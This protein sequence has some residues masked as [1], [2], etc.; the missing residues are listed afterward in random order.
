MILPTKVC[1]NF[2]TQVFNT[3][4]GCSLL[5][6]NFIFKSLWNFI[7]L[8]IKI[9]ILIFFMLSEILYAFNHL[10]GRFKSPLDSLFSFLIELLRHKRLASSAKWWSLQNF[11]AWLRSFI[12]NKNRRDPRADPWGMP[13]FIVVRPK[14][15]LFMDSYIPITIRQIGF[16]PIIWNSTNPI[17]IQLLKVSCGLQYQKLFVSLQKLHNQYFHHQELFLYSQLY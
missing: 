13:Q 12:Y 17:G 4:S 9:V 15:K 2:Y 1:I 10:T 5:P 16:K 3:F 8:D 14:S 11:F 6:H 7:W